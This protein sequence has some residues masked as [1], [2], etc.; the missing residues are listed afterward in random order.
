[1]KYKA[2][3]Q[4][5]TRLFCFDD[6]DLDSSQSLVQACEGTGPSISALPGTHL[7]P[8]YLKL[9][10]D[11]LPQGVEEIAGQYADFQ[12]ISFGDENNTS[13]LS[14]EICKWISGEKP[15]RV[16]NWQS[17]QDGRRARLVGRVE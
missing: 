11:D 3:L 5:K 2:D 14:T 17:D 1:M 9:G 16:P 6:D 10:L 8:V 4:A 7:T 12:N 13:Q 15:S